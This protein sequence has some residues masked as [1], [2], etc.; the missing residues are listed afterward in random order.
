MSIPAT[1]GGHQ[2]TRT[3]IITLL[4][5]S[6]PLTRQDIA[7]RLSLSLPTV[8]A[9]L[10]ALEAEGTLMRAGVRASTGGRPAVT[11]QPDTRRHAAIGV[12]IRS[13]EIVCLTVDLTGAVID[14]RHVTIAAR[15]DPIFYQ[16]VAHAV[17]EAAQAATR[18]GLRLLGVGLA[19]PAHINTSSS[20]DYA[21]IGAHCA[22]LT[23]LPVTDTE[24]YCAYAL[25]ECWARQRPDD[26]VCL[27]LGNHVGSAAVRAGRPHTA[28]VEHMCLDPAGPRCECG[29]RGCLNAYCSTACLA[30]DGE[31]LAGF[32]SVLEQ[33]ETHHRARM[34]AWCDSMAHAVANIRAVLPTD[35]VVCG[36][37]AEYL[38]DDEIARL[39]PA[40][41]LPAGGTAGGTRADTPRVLRGVGEPYQDAHGAALAIVGRHLETLRG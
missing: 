37:I 10:R 9:H 26:L 31:S 29:A 8:T 5:E 25:A 40:G 22:T 28:A 7:A 30:E 39:D 36:P 12:T 4:Y 41:R 14:E 32:F 20:L 24:R 23:G 34:R 15:T 33:G 13:T 16:R 27:F 35:V 3:A 2:D 6:G 21:Q 11:W 17:A 18:R 1:N 19:P 38:D